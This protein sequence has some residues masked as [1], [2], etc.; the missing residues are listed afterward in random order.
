MWS[1]I[2][3]LYLNLL[4]CCKNVIAIEG[5]EEQTLQPNYDS[6]QNKINWRI[7]TDQ[8]I[9]P[10]S[11]EEQRDGRLYKA[12]QLNKFKPLLPLN[13]INLDSLNPNHQ[14][15]SN[16]FTGSLNPLTLADLIAISQRHIQ[17]TNN[18]PST[19]RAIWGLSLNPT[20]H[21]HSDVINSYLETTLRQNLANVPKR[22]LSTLWQS[23]YYSASA[24]YPI[25]QSQLNGNSQYNPFISPIINDYA[26]IHGTTFENVERFDQTVEGSDITPK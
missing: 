8:I 15:S 13:P 17:P 19:R 24:L 7:R 1:C 14:L 9:A 25:V 12:L 11:T 5:R 26:N 4:Y 6:T 16:S 10:L 2:L 20:E 22:P 23:P 21:D 18:T 3:I